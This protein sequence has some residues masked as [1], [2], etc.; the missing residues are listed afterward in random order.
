MNDSLHISPIVKFDSVKF[1][2]I[3]LDLQT[4]STHNQSRRSII[5]DPQSILVFSHTR[6]MIKIDPQLT[7]T[8]S[9]LTFRSCSTQDQSRL[10]VNLSCQL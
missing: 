10:L 5:L 6:S 2:L 9:V 3:N 1:D 7:S 8:G 4:L